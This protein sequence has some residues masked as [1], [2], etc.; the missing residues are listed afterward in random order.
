MAVMKERKRPALKLL[1][2]AS[3]PGGIARQFRVQVWDR[4]SPCDWRLVG[5]FRDRDIASRCAAKLT[6]GGQEARVVDCRALPT[7][8]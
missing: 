8:A 1:V 4:E 2:S 6:A 7:A 3:C 5:S